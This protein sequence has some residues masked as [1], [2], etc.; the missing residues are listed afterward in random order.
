MAEVSP[1]MELARRIGEFRY[2]PRSH[3][4]FAYPWE[5]E[6]L[7]SSGPRTWQN[8]MF[9][10]I[11]EHLSS[12][13]TRHTPC[14]IAVAS[15]HGIGKSAGISMVNKWALD[16]CVDT[17]VVVTANTEGQLLTKTGPEL[18]KWCQ[19]ALTSDWFKPS[20]TSIASLMR[21]HDKAW[22]TDL[23]TWS[24]N[25]TEAFA[26]LHNQGKRI[27]LIFDE[28]S[29][30]A[31]KVWEVALGALTDEDTEIL[32]LAFGNPTQ[33][34]GAF[35]E[36][37][38]KA[39]NL[40]KTK[41]ID[42]RT[43]EGTNKAYLDELVR[44]YGE[45]SDIAKVRVRGL[46]PS[47]SSMQFIALDAVEAAQKRQPFDALG[48]E[49]VIFGVDCARMGDDESVLAIRCGRDAVSRPWKRWTKM[50]SMTLA[51]DIALEADKYHPDMIFVDAGNIGAA[52]VDRLRQLRPDVPVVE[53][54][55]G[56]EG[57]DAELEPGVRVHTAN[58]RAEM[59][60][61]MR[62]WLRGASIPQED[63][64]RD[65]LIGPTYS[66][67]GDDTSILLERKKDMKKRGLP[68]PDWGDALACTFAEPV[69]PRAVPGYLNPDN[70]GESGGD[71]YAELD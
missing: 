64:L 20:A 45:E 22:R 65:D 11:E 62:H 42:S 14:R 56:A 61:K 23:V 27:V 63:R 6:R 50:D 39:R 57:R 29:G 33:N 58:K 34:T 71:R 68:S 70:Y 47:A 38:G 21:G 16:T 15:G 41:Q 43:V 40:W 8:E 31:A 53:V 48:S 52:I 59:W 32:W 5:S 60:T 25:N 2:S 66:F 26:G 13:A 35:R 55:F 54:W 19:L 37:F 30:I 51:G 10:Q 44:T 67:G 1:K 28:A 18:T 12:P 4:L 3:A 49:P 9:L 7:P 17:R 69:M 24:E 46:F 36:C